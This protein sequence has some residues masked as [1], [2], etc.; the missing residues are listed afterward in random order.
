MLISRA[1]GKLTYVLLFFDVDDENANT[2]SVTF[3]Q[4]EMWPLHLRLSEE[5]SAQTGKYIVIYGSV[6][7]KHAAPHY[8]L[9]T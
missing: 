1:V 7:A 4:R 3:M 8:S 6:S 9:D 2:S 5:P